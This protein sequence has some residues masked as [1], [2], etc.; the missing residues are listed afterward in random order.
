MGQRLSLNVTRADP[1]TVIIEHEHHLDS[2][3]VNV[4]RLILGPSYSRRA[5][6]ADQYPLVLRGIS[7]ASTV[8]GLPKLREVICRNVRWH[9]DILPPF[10]C[11]PT[12][13][14]SSRI[15]LLQPVWPGDGLS[16]TR[17]NLIHRTL[18]ALPITPFNSG[19]AERLIQGRSEL[20]VAGV[21]SIPAA[22][23]IFLGLL[24]LLPHAERSVFRRLVVDI[25]GSQTATIVGYM[26]AIVGHLVEDLSIRWSDPIGLQHV[27]CEYT[28]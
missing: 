23:Y 18:V 8:L 7:V 28:E 15:Y 13:S 25:R 9:S 11:R 22:P 14:E 21:T 10:A 27:S 24:M 19:Q 3:P 6:G 26:L 1:S 12:S 4:E 16:P 20:E 2:I 5:H 17:N